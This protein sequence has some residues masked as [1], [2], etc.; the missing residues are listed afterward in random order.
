MEVTELTID[1]MRDRK[2]ELGY[3]YKQLSEKSGVPL[4]TIQKIFNGETKSPRH[5]TLVML[6]RVLAPS[7]NG[8]S[9]QFSI[10]DEGRGGMLCEEPAFIFGGGKKVDLEHFN[11]KR[12]GEY[13][14]E[15]YEMLPDD[16]RVELIDGYFYYLESP[17]MRHQLIIGELYAQI[18]NFIRGNKG[19]CIPFMAPADVQLDKD[20]KTILQPDVF[21]V[22]DPDKV[23]EKRIYGNP[24]FVVEILSPSTSRKDRFIKAKKYKY[25]GVKEF[26]LVDPRKKNVIVYSFDENDDDDITIY[27]FDDNIPIGVY[28]GKLQIDFNDIAEYVDSVCGP[29]E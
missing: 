10:S 8:V 3:S 5:D 17:S 19:R 26:W 25:A 11:G 18:R 13:S 29:I 7:A 12:Q 2:R 14:L 23:T 21:I 16:V 22:C 15:D 1:E 27:G 24:D 28:E 20:D 9:P 4:G 6:Q